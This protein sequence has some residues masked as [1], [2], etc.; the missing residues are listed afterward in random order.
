MIIA[1][2]DGIAKVKGLNPNEKFIFFAKVDD[3]IGYCV[4]FG[5]KKR[6]NSG[7]KFYELFDFQVAFGQ[8][9]K[10]MLIVPVKHGHKYKDGGGMVETEFG[11]IAFRLNVRG[12]PSLFEG[13]EVEELLF[14]S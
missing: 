4:I 11:N 3:Q 2:Q 5:P 7:R 6:S 10:K 9:N 8:L 12:E 1:K 14:T 13:V